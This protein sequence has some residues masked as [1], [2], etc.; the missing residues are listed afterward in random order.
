M[1]EDAE[2]WM[3]RLWDD[4]SEDIYRFA[5][6][7]LPDLADDVTSQT[8]LVAWRR[9]SDVPAQPRPW[10]FGVA[11]NIVMTTV[12][13]QARYD[14]LL[15]RA[16]LA[17]PVE[18]GQDVAGEALEREAHRSAW[19]ALAPKDREVL[20]LVAWDGLTNAEASAVLGCSAPAFAVRLL[21]ARRSL[22]RALDRALAD[23]PD[24][25]VDGVAD[26]P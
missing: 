11:R 20:A 12:R 6:R 7:R 17:L 4:H 18:S 25:R 16:Q 21:R 5:Y 22:D 1:G 15:A 3:R 26:V 14:A 13:G 2:A 9:R 10:L 8:F 19:A 24:V 23:Q